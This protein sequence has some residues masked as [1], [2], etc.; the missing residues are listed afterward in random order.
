MGIYLNPGGDQFRMDRKLEIYVDKS[1]MLAYL[2]RVFRS[3]NRFVCVSRPRRFGKS[4]GANMVAA[5]YDRTAEVEQEFSGLKI[6]SEPTFAEH[7][8]KYDV[9]KLNIQMFLSESINVDDLL[10]QI[11]KAILWELL[12]TYPDFR[13]FDKKKL[14]R[15]MSDVY[16]NTKR[17]FVIIIDEWDC[18]FREYKNRKDWQE[19]YLDFLRLWL[20]DQTYVGL[21]YMTGIL[22]IKKY[23]THSALNMFREFS[24]TGPGK[25]AEYVGFTDAEVEDLCQRFNMDLA[26]CK[27]W[28]DGYNLPRVGAVYCP[29]SVALSMDEG[30]FA[31]YWNQTET[32]EDLKMYIDMNYDGLKEAVIALM[33]GARQKV[34]PY[35][36]TN[37]MTTFHSK[38]DVLTLLVHLGYL[39]FDSKTEEVYIP[40]QE[41]MLE[42]GNAVQNDN[43]W[44]VVAEAINA[45]D[46]LLSATLAKDSNA[47]AKG[48][49]K[50][51]LETS[52]LQYNDENALSYTISLAYYTARQ[53][54]HVTRELP[55]G[56]GFADIVMCPRVNHLD[57]PALILELK[58]DK[59]ADTAIKQI[60]EKNY[61]QAVADYTGKILLV[62]V[63]YDKN[64]R[65]H[66]CKIEEWQKE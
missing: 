61:P 47:V 6:E 27:R 8:G 41:I 54:Y 2:N 48:I 21:A 9:I 63:S 18:I 25:L 22:P 35:T 28:Y 36:F 23:G 49:D 5:Y 33:A 31:P 62:G 16:S 66:E 43:S 60:K 3:A 55:T 4:M 59:S 44:D 32:F 14:V 15:T 58:W 37:D 42:Y 26:E 12:D 52:H 46:N 29:R 39:G 20:K 53:K 57:L 56:K 13:Y 64:T 51:H 34:N 24:M 17:S 30:E 40:N 1:G 45:S 50:A 11:Q 10:S 7:L 19:K 65:V 38:D